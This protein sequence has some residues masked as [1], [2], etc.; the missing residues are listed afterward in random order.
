MTDQPVPVPA[1]QS[2]TGTDRHSVEWVAAGLR[3]AAAQV[4]VTV[5][6]DYARAVAVD[7]LTRNR[8][9]AVSRVGAGIVIHTKPS[10]HRQLPVLLGYADSRGQWHRDGRRHTTAQPALSAGVDPAGLGPVA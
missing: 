3:R 1:Q 5:P 8:E 7:G 10:S 4:G 6:V 9:L 2:P